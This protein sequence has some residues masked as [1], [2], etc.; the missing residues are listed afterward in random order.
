MG[1]GTRWH[2]PFFDREKYWGG[3]GNVF[4]K[5]KKGQ[6]FI[7]SF[8]KYHKFLSPNSEIAE[9][10][11]LISNQFSIDYQLEKE[12]WFATAAIYGKKNNAAILQENNILGAEVFLRWSLENVKT[13]V[14]LASVQSTLKSESLEYPS[15]HD[16]GYYFRAQLKWNIPKWFEFNAIYKH[17]QGRYYLP[18]TGRSYH[19]TTDTYIPEYAH[20]EEGLRLSDYRLLDVSFS[21]MFSVGGGVL[22]TFISVN[23]ILDF[24]NLRGYEYNEDYSEK[25][26]DYFSRRVLFFG[27]V[28]QWQ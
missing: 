7:F 24:K 28:Y 1:A 15:P 19:E 17:R 12:N 14:S 11:L 9:T 10:T 3:Q 27:G 22:I 25:S 2:G 18:I 21:R 5:I 4:Y 16:L 8:G 20:I 26:A 6:R 23:N 13:S